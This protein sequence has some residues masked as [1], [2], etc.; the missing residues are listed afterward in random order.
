MT[1]LFSIRHASDVRR[2][3]IYEYHKV[4]IPVS[5]ISR[6][7]AVEMLPLPS[8]LFLYIIPF[9]PVS[10]QRMYNICATG[11]FTIMLFYLQKAKQFLPPHSLYVCLSSQRVCSSLAVAHVSLLRLA[12]TAAGAVS[13]KGNV[14]KQS[15]RSYQW[16]CHYFRNRKCFMV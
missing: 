4:D 8:K 1:S 13:Y 3:T 5:K 10:I 14:E 9:E 7:T 11:Y 6:L 2:R 12:L 16:I 15:K